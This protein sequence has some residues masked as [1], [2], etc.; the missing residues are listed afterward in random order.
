MYMVQYLVRVETG[1]VHGTIPGQG[2]DWQ[3]T[4]YNTWS[5]WRLAVYMVQYLVRVETGSVHGTIPGQGGDWQRTWYK[6]KNVS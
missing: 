4:W 1:S 5:G 6:A 2:G 3:C